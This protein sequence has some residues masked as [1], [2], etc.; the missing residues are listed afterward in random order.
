MGR[1]SKH[2]LERNKWRNCPECARVYRKRFLETTKGKSS[3]KESQ[4]RH[5]KSKRGNA[6]IKTRN[7]L[8]K[9]G[10]VGKSQSIAQH[11]VEYAMRL[12]ML[13]KHSCK[14]CNNPI[15][16]AH[17]LFGYDKNNRL[18]VIFLCSYHHYKANRDKSFNEWLKSI[19]KPF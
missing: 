5:R 1:C 18:K 19:Y 16:E 12:G 17:H 2:N 11:S 8:Y 7:H 10:A 6:L 13:V 14:I 4:K 3:V 9:T 15:S